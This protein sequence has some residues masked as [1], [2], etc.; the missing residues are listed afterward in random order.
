MESI[1]K[2]LK[3]SLCGELPCS[4]VSLPCLHSFCLSCLQKRVEGLSLPSSQLCIPVNLPS[5]SII[6]TVGHKK[7]ECPQC[8]TAFSLPPNGLVKDLLPLPFTLAISSLKPEEE[9]PNDKLCELCEENLATFYCQDCPEYHCDA[10]HAI[11]KKSKAGRNHTYVSLDHLDFNRSLPP[12]PL[13]CPLH[14]HLEI[15][16]FCVH[17]NVPVCPKCAVEDHGDHKISALSQAI[18]QT[19]GDI[20]D[21]LQ[22]VSL[23]YSFI[24]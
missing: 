7:E 6:E 14:P 11:H 17:D 10:C 4:P 12:R 20:L 21:K 15:D 1:Y 9:D 16:A 19:K 5:L 13:L 3:C 2:T 24:H 8:Q 18:S 22:E 23:I